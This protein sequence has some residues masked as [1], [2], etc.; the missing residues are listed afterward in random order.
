MSRIRQLKP[1]FWDDEKLNSIREVSA[2]MYI[3]LWNM[4]DDYSIT[5][6]SPYRIKKELYYYRLD[7]SVEEIARRLGELQKIKRI[8]LFNIEDEPYMYIPTLKNHQYIQKPSIKPNISWEKMSRYID[9]QKRPTTYKEGVEVASRFINYVQSNLL[10]QPDPTLFDHVPQETPQMSTSSMASVSEDSHTGT[11][12]LTSFPHAEAVGY[13]HQGSEALENTTGTTTVVPIMYMGMDMYMDMG[14]CNG[15]L[16]THDKSQFFEESEEKPL[17]AQ[18]GPPGAGG[19]ESPAEPAVPAVTGRKTANPTLEACRQ[20]FEKCMGQTCGID[21]ARFQASQ[22]FNFYEANGWVQGGRKPIVNW[23]ASANSWILENVDK[24]RHKIE[25]GRLQVVKNRSGAG[26]L[27]TG[28]NTLSTCLSEEMKKIHLENLFQNFIRDPD[29]I[30]N[31]GHIEYKLLNDKG[32]ISLSD[33]EKHNLK[34]QAAKIRGDALLQ[35]NEHA[36]K[37]MAEI[38]FKGDID[39]P[40]LRDDRPEYYL[41]QKRLCIELTFQQLKAA[42]VKKLFEHVKKEA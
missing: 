21:K 2:S 5:F 26:E 10:K 33:T 29:T 13:P 17:Q 32:F 14:M 19:V 41:L 18:E 38:Y 39:H 20:Y 8:F 15:P 9:I 35:I 16:A 37:L 1:E 3:G 40:G 24:S 42:G 7:V 25:R 22:F 30:K 36:K 28:I 12:A 23:V 31:A 4:C 27:S 6:A 34:M 11:V